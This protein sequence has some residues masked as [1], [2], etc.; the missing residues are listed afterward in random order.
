MCSLLMAD[1]YS[2]H[3]RIILTLLLLDQRDIHRR[4]SLLHKM[5][6]MPC[7]LSYWTYTTT[8][9]NRRFKILT[10]HY[11]LSAIEDL[12]IISKSIAEINPCC[13]W[14]GLGLFL[15][16]WFLVVG[17][18]WLIGW[19]F[20]IPVCCLWVFSFSGFFLW[21]WFLIIFASKTD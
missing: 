15:L 3:F 7:Q 14:A 11:S 10:K 12:R 4:F 13:C 20:L 18:F 5:I 21:V 17:F 8:D 9:D 2:K 1:S 19:Y 16:G 6:I